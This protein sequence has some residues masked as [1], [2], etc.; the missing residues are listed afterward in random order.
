MTIFG[1]IQLLLKVNKLF[2]LLKEADVKKNPWTTAFGAMTAA[3]MG[4]AQVEDPL[5]KT[6]GQILVILGP[7]GLG[8]AAKDAVNTDASK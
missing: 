4:M 3:G 6:I 8:W 7:L 1:K 2:E 5:I